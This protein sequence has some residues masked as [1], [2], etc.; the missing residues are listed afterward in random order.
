[1]ASLKVSFF[2]EDAPQIKNYGPVSSGKH[3]KLLEDGSSIPAGILHPSSSD[4]RCFPAG[5]GD[6]L[7]SSLQDPVPGIFDLGLRKILAACLY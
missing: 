6:L 1:V 2:Y 4:I 3:R 5:Y 7:A